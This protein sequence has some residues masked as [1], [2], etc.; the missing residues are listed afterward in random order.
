MLRFRGIAPRRLAAL[1][2][3][4]LLGACAGSVPN[5]AGNVPVVNVPGARPSPQPLVA[6]L[7][8][9]EGAG[10]FAVVILLHGCG[11]ITNNQT[12]WVQRLN[13]WGYGAV[14]LDSLGPRGVKSVCPA[15]LQPMVTR[16]DRAGDVV[17]AVRWL[18]TV[19]RVDGARLAVLGNSHGGATAATVANRH[20][21]AEGGGLVK[22]AVDYYG[23]CREPADHG[24]IPLLALA[25]DDD[26][27]SYPARTCTEFARAV[28]SAEN[29]TVRTSPGVV[30]AFDNSRLVQRTWQEGHP[31]QYDHDAAE[32]SFRE[33]HTFLDRTIGP[34]RVTRR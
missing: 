13:G 30:H 32:A 23:P 16:Q 17:A 18:Q 14:V 9:P 6:R 34:E 25:G 4:P 19:P 12:Q 7:F 26:T 10:P 20:F 1:V 15:Y 21:E 11:G 8:L 28:G 31:M 27:W 22:A 29:V 3:L 24:S 5:V 33:V 2:C